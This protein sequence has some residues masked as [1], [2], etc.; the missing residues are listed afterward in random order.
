M[1]GSKI[2]TQ[3]FK[4]AKLQSRFSV[5]FT[6]FLISAVWAVF[7]FILEPEYQA[8]SQLLIEE[9]TPAA[10][11]RAVE[12]NRIDSQ[13]IEAY[14]SFATSP[15]ILDKVKKELELK[16]S[17]TDLRQKIQVDHASN[18]PVLTVTVSSEDS[19]QA[20]LIAN[21][22]SFIFQNEVKNSLKADHV[23]IISQA[24]SEEI[25]ES[26]S[27][28]RLMLSLSIAVAS[29]F[30]F[31]ILI[32]FITAATKGAVKATNRDIRKKENQMQTVFK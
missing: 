19:R 8:S 11:H 22:L 23:S 14:A 31:S 2:K 25:K 27:Q 12:S 15:E 3:L 24:S 18:S 30:I 6:I 21:R 20:V 29:G 28:N 17:I 13:I 26:P 16:S 9:S 7:A 5:L 10:L 1:T 4:K 32:G